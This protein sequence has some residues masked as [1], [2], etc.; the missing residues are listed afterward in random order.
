MRVIKLATEW[1]K[2]NEVLSN[3]FRALVL[4]IIVS[5]NSASWNDI[6][7][8]LDKLWGEFNPNT[9]SFHLNR[10]IEAGLVEKVQMGERHIYRATQTG[11]NRTR[12]EAGELL[13]ELGGKHG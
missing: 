8:T 1:A 9:L 5:K 4:A 10:L 11:I 7:N 12:A 3:P 2:E 13:A 6:K